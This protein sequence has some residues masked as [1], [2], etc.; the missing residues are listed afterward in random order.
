M[1]LNNAS[2]YATLDKQVNARIGTDEFPLK[3]NKGNQNKH[4]QKSHSFNPD[5]KK[6][7]L[8]GDLSTAQ[9]LFDKYHGSGE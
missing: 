2:D 8:F 6:S 5:E 1:K 3:I 4:I 9:E 7:I